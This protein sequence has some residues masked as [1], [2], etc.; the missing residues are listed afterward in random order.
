MASAYANILEKKQQR[1]KRKRKTAISREQ[2]STPT[3][4]VWNTNMAAASLFGHRE[5]MRKRSILK[6]EIEFKNL[7]SFQAQEY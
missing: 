2:S 4:L 1:Q 6:G 5:V 7:H 3:G